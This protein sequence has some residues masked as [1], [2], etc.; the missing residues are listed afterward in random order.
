MEL[1]ANSADHC[2]LRI[3][4]SAWFRS[5][6][7]AGVTST[8][9]LMVLGVD[10]V[11]AG[12]SIQAS[13]VQPSSS[14]A[15]AEQVV[16]VD[17]S[18]AQPGQVVS[19]PVDT[20]ITVTPVSTSPEE[21]ESTSLNSTVKPKTG[22]TFE[23]ANTAI[24]ATEELT[25]VGQNWPSET[26]YQ[27]G[28]NDEAEQ[29]W[30]SAV[31]HSEE[32][33]VD[34]VKDASE[35]GSPH[36]I[37][38]NRSDFKVLNSVQLSQDLAMLPAEAGFNLS[39]TAS[40]FS[41]TDPQAFVL[42]ASVNHASAASNLAQATVEA[43]A[44]EPSNLGSER[45]P[46]AAEGGSRLLGGPVVLVQGVYVFQGN[47][48]SGRG[49]VTGAY[50]IT[51]NLLVGATVDVTGGDAFS[52]S[53]NDGID[54][55]ELYFAVSPPSYSNLRL[56]VGMVDLTG[57]FDRNSFAKDAATQFLNPVFQT[58]PA[59]SAV[60]IGSRPAVLLNWS[61]LDNLEIKAAGFSSDRNL[62]N[63]ALDGFAGEVDLRFGNF[64]VRGTYATD[65]DRG[66]DDGFRE[67][68][69]ISRGNDRFGLRSNDREQ[70]YGL[71]AELFIPEIKL[72]LF[73]RYGWYENL[74]LDRGGQTYSVG[75]NFLDLFKQNDRLG[76]AYGREL[77]NNNLRQERDDKFPDVWELFYD[78]PITRNLRI[79]ATLQS[80][81]QFSETIAGFRIRADFDVSELGRLFR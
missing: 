55:N 8:S 40:S 14:S 16:A 66:H 4:Q 69:Q 33:S 47:E 39:D 74:D 17:S 64:I 45:L 23:Q 31:D 73:G 70:A 11:L 44:S 34:S 22:T 79:G 35:P 75:L 37:A 67:I 68:Y 5:V 21:I 6:F 63:F 2:I 71:N 56:V 59:L 42:P 80:R 62:G 36:E 38:A 76:L 43:P 65:R 19:R 9:T 10:P 53:P 13:L 26:D 32:T 12:Q 25:N 60:G 24:A 41:S 30:R 1:N 58:N 51:P 72:G 49:R 81:E 78:L 20:A 61:I 29:S 46:E 18:L 54:L 3:S 28:V 7:W 57:Y 27:Y 77:S 50:A 48:S 52:D 15:Q